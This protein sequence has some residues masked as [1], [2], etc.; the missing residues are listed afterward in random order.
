MKWLLLI[1]LAGFILPGCRKSNDAGPK[2]RFELKGKQYSF[3]KLNAIVGGQGNFRRII[4][5][6]TDLK[7]GSNFQM[8]ANAPQKF[9]G[10][11]YRRRPE[12]YEYNIIGLG[13]II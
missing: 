6:A 11:Y 7:T 2:F 13:I 5:E 8:A 3:D 10:E 4:I 9:Q 12:P 1:C